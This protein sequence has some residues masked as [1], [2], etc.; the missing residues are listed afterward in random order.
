M[1]FTEIFVSRVILIFIE[2]LVLASSY[3]KVLSS[4]KLKKNS[5]KNHVL[6]TDT[7][8]FNFRHSKIV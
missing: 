3:N 4:I 2:K 7:S 5:K 6:A 8:Y 1:T